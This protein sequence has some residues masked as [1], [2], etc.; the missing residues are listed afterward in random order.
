M[1]ILVMDVP[2][3]RLLM[4]MEFGIAI[5][6]ILIFVKNVLNDFG[7]IYIRICFY[8]ILIYLC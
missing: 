6:V 1:L 4:I 8:C 2:S 7:K 5:N 3:L